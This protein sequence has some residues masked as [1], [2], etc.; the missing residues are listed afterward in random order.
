MPPFAPP[1][2][3]TEVQNA[4]DAQTSI[5][6]TVV[7]PLTS[8]GQ[9]DLFTADYSGS[10][11]VLKVYS[12][13]YWARAEREC[14]ALAL[15]S[16]DNIVKLLSWG[17]VNIR[18]SSCIFTITEFIEG[19][20]LRERILRAPMS[21]QE[22]R[23]LGSDIAAVIQELWAHRIVHRDIKP[24]N[25]MI[26]TDGTAVILDLGIARYRDLPTITTWGISLGTAGY[27]S[28]EQAR[29]RRGLTYKS[30]FFS[31]GLVLYEA[32]T[33]THPF[34]RDQHLIVGGQFAPPPLKQVRRVSKT[35]SE[36]VASLL[37]HN[38]LDRPRDCASLIAAL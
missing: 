6:V 11:A 4:F 25:I 14:Q 24:K 18:S 15:L 28:P 31:L 26:R 32:L 22:A 33:Q 38:P 29:G 3:Q 19:E 7:A 21:E 8:G 30:D 20:T 37:E 5:Q 34:H 9:A 13:A 12:A 17:Q 2:S 27:M 36:T 16:S 1:L 10:Q 35:L 23:R